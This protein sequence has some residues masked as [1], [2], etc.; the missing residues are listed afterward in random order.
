VPAWPSITSN[1]NSDEQQTPVPAPPYPPSHYAHSLHP[2]PS[3]AGSSGADFLA[4]LCSLRHRCALQRHSRD[5]HRCPIARRWQTK[6]CDNLPRVCFRI[7]VLDRVRLDHLSPVLEG[8]HRR[9]NRDGVSKVLVSI[10]MLAF[11]QCRHISPVISQARAGIRNKRA[12]NLYVPRLAQ[13][14]DL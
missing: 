9:A 1:C 11:A 4:V 12:I 10:S 8:Q 3:H 7:V 14:R 6:V 5:T 2:S 13:N